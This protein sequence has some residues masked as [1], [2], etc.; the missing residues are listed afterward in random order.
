MTHVKTKKNNEE[1][2]V[3][4]YYRQ[5]AHLGSAQIKNIRNFYDR[6]SMYISS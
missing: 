1:K 4:H 2:K 3:K 5:S 6:K